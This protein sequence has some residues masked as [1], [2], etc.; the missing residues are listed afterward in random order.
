MRKR[1]LAVVALC[2]A[3]TAAAFGCAG[4]EV[5]KVEDFVDFFVEMP[6][7]RPLRILQL[8]DTQI[9]DASQ[10][11]RAD[12][13]SVYEKNIYAKNKIDE[14]CFDQIRRIVGRAEPDLI[15]LT[16]DIVYG[17][18]DD[19]GSSL[20]AV[21]ALMESFGVPWAPV[22]GNHD[23]ESAM[24]VEWQNQQF[25]NAEH[26]LFRTRPEIIGNGN[27]TIG[28]RRNEELL[29]VIYMMDSNGCGYSWEENTNMKLEPGF[30][31]DQTEW[32]SEIASGIDLAAGRKVPSFLAL[33]IP[34]KEFETALIAAGY[35][36]E[37]DAAFV[38][39]Y[40]LGAEENDF[41]TKNGDFGTKGEKL[42]IWS[43][44][45]FLEVL[46]EAGID[47]VFAGHCHQNNFSVLYE[48]IRFTFGL[49]TGYYDYHTKEQ[50]GG[51]LISVIEDGSF[52]V[53]HLYDIE[54]V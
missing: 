47:G 19:D 23:N 11:R 48:G 36:D 28:I 24:G 50:T 40:T 41:E 46:K 13:L 44:N 6:E 38:F 8:T 14:M 35:Q 9:I 31:S 43:Q 29:R 34:P 45:G 1:I 37:R 52:T 7:G 4:E 32:L 15:L 12:R 21:V 26:C 53:N 27:Y 39:K 51:T 18:F 3:I 16:G 25:L 22:Y 30:F 5:Y 33:H 54:S 20:Q 42:S 10:A 17:E 2:A 49:K